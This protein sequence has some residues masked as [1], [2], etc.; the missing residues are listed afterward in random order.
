[1]DQFSNHKTESSR[2]VNDKQCNL[3]FSLLKKP[4][5]SYFQNLDSKVVIDNKKF[6]ENSSTLFS[7]KIERKITLVKSN[8]I[9]SD[10]SKIAKIFKNYCNKIVANLYINQNL[11]CVRVIQ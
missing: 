6:G 2:I 11:E 5:T 8:E 3:Y 9:I 10:D 4:K 1:M 7:N